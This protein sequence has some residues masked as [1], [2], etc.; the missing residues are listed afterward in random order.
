MASKISWE[1]SYRNLIICYASVKVHDVL[2]ADLSLFIAILIGSARCVAAVHFTRF[3]QFREGSCQFATL[4]VWKSWKETFSAF[5]V[6]IIRSDVWIIVNTYL[7]ICMCTLVVRKLAT[8]V[9]GVIKNYNNIRLLKLSIYIGSTKSATFYLTLQDCKVF[10]V[11]IENDDDSLFCNRM[12]AFSWK[13]INW[14]YRNRSFHNRLGSIALLL[15]TAH[16]RA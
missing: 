13:A 16:F 3:A 15:T 10:G 8:R 6:I 12:C 11:D 9:R 2:H 5:A 4:R 7:Y 1:Q 14:C